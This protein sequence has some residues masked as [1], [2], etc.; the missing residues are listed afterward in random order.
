MSGAP[1][2]SIVGAYFPAWM[3]CALLGI[4]GTVVARAVFSGLG[5]NAIL[6]ARLFV[7]AS[8]G[9]IVSI[10]FWIGWFQR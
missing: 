5:L 9:V 7:Y 10:A 8:I 4:V 6:P 1:T 3:L 2:F